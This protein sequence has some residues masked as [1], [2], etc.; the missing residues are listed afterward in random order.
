MDALGTWLADRGARHDDLVIRTTP[1]G[2]GVYARRPIAAGAVVLRVPRALVV[3]LEDVQRS[4]IGHQL[5]DLELSSDHTLLAAWLLAEDLDPSSPWRSFLDALPRDLRGFPLHASPDDQSLLHGTVAGALLEE[6]RTNLVLDHLALQ[7]RAPRCGFSRDAV[8]WARLTVGSRLYGLTIDDL[9]TSALVPFGDMFNHDPVGAAATWG[10]DD[11]AFTITAVREL[12]ADA[13][14]CI[15][16]GH[17]G[18]SRLLVHYGFCLDD[19]PH[20]EAELFVPARF[21]VTRDPT[22]PSAGAMLAWLG[23]HR[24]DAATAVTAAARSALAALSTA[25]GGAPRLARPRADALT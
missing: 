9:A 7:G 2:R 21:R 19:N 11:D 22:H 24:F 16:Y 23:A 15:D 10:Y 17:K 14:V 5:R 20:D 25:P 12:A 3:T 13:E 1:A 6:L 18:N 8:T 4:S